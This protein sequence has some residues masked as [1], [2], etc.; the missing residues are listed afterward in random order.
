MG[1]VV[2]IIIVLLWLLGFIQIPYIHSTI[3]TLLGKPITLYNILLFLIIAWII[4][5]LPAPLR[6]IVFVLFILWILSTLGILAFA[7]LSQILIVA[8]II[9]VILSLF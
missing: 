1:S 6:Q 2:L 7:G 8:I 9:G 3:F 5:I 4:E